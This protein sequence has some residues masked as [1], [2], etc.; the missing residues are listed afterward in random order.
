MRFYAAINKVFWFSSLAFFNLTSYAVTSAEKQDL[1][2]R[3]LAP[4]SAGSTKT[5]GSRVSHP[6]N[7]ISNISDFGT[8]L[9]Q[10]IKKI[11]ILGGIAL[12]LF[13]II[14]YM[15]H[16]KNSLETPLFMVIIVFLF[17][18]ALVGLSFAPLKF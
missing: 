15:R 13:S 3:L 10:L 8:G 9:A 4:S 16:R 18:L 14:L 1:A 6:G 11:A 17:G 2:R 5:S 7:E 12:V